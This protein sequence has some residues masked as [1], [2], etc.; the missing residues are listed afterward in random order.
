MTM[1]RLVVGMFLVG[2]M[3]FAAGVVSGQNYPNKV[4][5]IVT[6]AP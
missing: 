4:V 2:M 6:T 3:V 1:P 5:R